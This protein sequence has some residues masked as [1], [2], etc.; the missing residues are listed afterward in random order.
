MDFLKSSKLKEA[1]IREPLYCTSLKYAEVDVESI[2]NLAKLRDVYIS[3]IVDID[4][5]E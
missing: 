5:C 4:V 1:G 3:S 2:D